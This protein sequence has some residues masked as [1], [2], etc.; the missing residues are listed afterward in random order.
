MDVDIRERFKNKTTT[1]KCG[2]LHTSSL[3]PLTK[4]KIFFSFLDVSD[5]FLAKKKKK[6]Q[7]CGKIIRSDPLP[8]SKCG[9]FHTFFNPSLS[10]VWTFDTF[11]WGILHR[12]TN[13]S[14]VWWFKSS[15][16]SVALVKGQSLT[17]NQP[18]KPSLFHL[19]KLVSN[20]CMIS[21]FSWH[22]I[23]MPT[24]PN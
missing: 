10:R 13:V 21:L 5:H 3:P 16:F 18:P 23:L 2:I 15:D 11:L 7:K 9:K 12:I 4:G 22:S 20:L 1:K 19:L 8:P 6:K 17:L 24:L 14:N